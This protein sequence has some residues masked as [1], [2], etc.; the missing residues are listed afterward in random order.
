MTIKWPAW[1]TEVTDRPY[2]TENTTLAARLDPTMVVPLYMGPV[3][4][5]APAT[6]LHYE[7][8]R[9]CWTADLLD[10]AL[11]EDGQGS[12]Y[13][14]NPSVAGFNLGDFP[15]IGPDAELGEVAAAQWRRHAVK[16]APLVDPVEFVNRWCERF[17]KGEPC[18]LPKHPALRAP[19]EAFRAAVAPAAA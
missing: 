8:A 4:G 19:C 18:K 5:E 17:A 14:H 6:Q 2:A 15:A 10:L 7:I 9:L 12:V 11:H 13:I 3:A 16:R 1:A